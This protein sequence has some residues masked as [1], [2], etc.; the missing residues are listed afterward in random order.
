[1]SSMNQE[2]VEYLRVQLGALVELADRLDLPV[3][4]AHMSTALDRIPQGSDR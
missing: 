2:S 4:A 1:M 3:V